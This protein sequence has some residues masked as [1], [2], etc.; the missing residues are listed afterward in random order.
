MS[1]TN[2]SGKPLKAKPP[3]PSFPLIIP[4]AESQSTLPKINDKPLKMPILKIQPRLRRR[5]E[6]E[7]RRKGAVLTTIRQL[8]LL[9]TS[10]WM[11]CK[12]LSLKQL[13]GL[14]RIWI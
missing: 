4:S 8:S 14:G 3:I 5:K 11:L 12:T 9:K 1:S 10:N 7:L 13:M 2:Y 6:S